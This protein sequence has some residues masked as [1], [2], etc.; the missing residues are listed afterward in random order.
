MRAFTAI[1][2]I[3]FGLIFVVHIA[4]LVAEGAGPLHNP[5]FILMSLVSLVLSIW[6]FVLLFRQGKKTG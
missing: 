1:A 4:R 5:L 2:G 3:L 6:S